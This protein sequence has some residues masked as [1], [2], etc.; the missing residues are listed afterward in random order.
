MTIQTI[1][2]VFLSTYINQMLNMHYT[3]SNVSAVAGICF[4]SLA[5]IIFVYD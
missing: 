4:P 5:E 3:V 2:Y 1:A